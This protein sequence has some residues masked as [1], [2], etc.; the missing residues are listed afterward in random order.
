MPQ[1]TA[2]LLKGPR[3][4]FTIIVG[5]ADHNTREWGYSNPP[6]CAESGGLV[7][8]QRDLWHVFFRSWA[9]IIENLINYYISRARE[10]FQFKPDIAL[11]F[12]SSPVL[13][14]SAPAIQEEF[15][16]VFFL[17]E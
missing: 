3:G 8:I 5:S 7:L 11:I 14:S 6:P 1:G 9:R 16:R 4:Y 17:T 2:T 12:W 10:H 15:C 13:W